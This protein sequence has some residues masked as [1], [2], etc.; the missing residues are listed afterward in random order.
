MTTI[1]KNV[2]INKLDG[3]VNKC[4]NRYHRTIK[5]IK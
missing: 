2:Q 3:I 1:S 5:Q 4:N